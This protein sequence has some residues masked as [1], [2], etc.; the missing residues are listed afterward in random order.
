MLGPSHARTR[1][2][3]EGRTTTEESLSL[4][5]KR[6]E[7]VSVLMASCCQ[8]LVASR[9][10]AGLQFSNSLG[11]A[12]GDSKIP[13]SRRLYL[14]VVFPEDI[15]VRPIHMFFS[16]SNEG[17]KVLEAA[18][19]AA[20]LRMDRGRIVGSPGN[21]SAH[22]CSPMQK[23]CQPQPGPLLLADRLNLFTLEG[24]LLRCDLDLEAHIPSTLQPNSW[25]ILEKGNRVSPGRL[26][27]IRQAAVDAQ[28]GGGCLV[29]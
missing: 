23:A 11:S 6:S 28:S 7:P 12:I 20:G 22:P 24:D 26:A 15:D 10:P 17:T 5:H 8:C 4:L 19:S 21:R 16:L 13:L 18:C 29:M 3:L 14:G 27:A 2:D 1:K 25:V 9:T